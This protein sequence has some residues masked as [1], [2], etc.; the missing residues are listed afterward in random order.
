MELLL[1]TLATWSIVEIWHHGSI[2]ESP[3]SMLFRWSLKK[4]T[5]LSVVPRWIGALFSCPFCLSV[6]VALILSLTYRFTYPIIIAFAACRLANLAND[7]TQRFNVSR[8]PA[9]D[10]Y[11]Y[12]IKDKEVAYNVEEEENDESQYENEVRES[13]PSNQED[14][15]P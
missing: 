12:K 14:V 6:W 15:Q 11:K 5:K 9:P 10:Y 3:R 8:S 7:L 4:I 1:V 13:A 2:F